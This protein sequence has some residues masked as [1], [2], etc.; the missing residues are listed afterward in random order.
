M[1]TFK[2]L[3]LGLIIGA[4]VGS[5]LADDLYPPPWR[6]LPGST[7][8]QWEFS[9][10]ANPAA[11]TYV[12][13][14]Y[15][16]PSAMVLGNFPYTRWKNTD[17]GHQGVW[18]FEDFMVFMLPNADIQNPVKYIWVQVTYSADGGA[19][20]MLFTIP[21]DVGV[22]QTVNKTQLDAYYWHG[23]YLLTIEPNPVSEQLWLEPRD[24]T[25]YVDQV[26]IDTI[27]IPEPSVF[28]LMALGGILSLRRR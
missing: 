22:V 14:P 20:P 9:T 24:C 8:Q 25:I 3:A 21:P 4:V 13:N 23:T 2:T 19:D 28:A 7:Y 17:Y 10:N 15:G 6:G 1:S 11:P 5:A 27:C 18:Q 12:N 26:V 16:T